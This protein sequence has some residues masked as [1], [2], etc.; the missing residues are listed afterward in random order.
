MQCMQSDR[1]MSMLIERTLIA[2]LN[3]W[4]EPARVRPISRLLVTWNYKYPYS[5]VSDNRE[6]LSILFSKPA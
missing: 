1:T 5:G 3:P 2:S 6:V 4:I